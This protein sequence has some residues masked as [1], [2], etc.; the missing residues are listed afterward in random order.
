MEK[1]EDSKGSREGKHAVTAAAA[2]AAAADGF[3]M[4]R[5]LQI[6]HIFVFDLQRRTN[7]TT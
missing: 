2:A 4:Y 6:E 5:K 3:M 7:E 1:M